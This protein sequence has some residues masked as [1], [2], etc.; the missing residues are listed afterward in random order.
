MNQPSFKRLLP[1]YNTNETD[2]YAMH[3]T[4]RQ[5]DK[6]QRDRRGTSKSRK[7]QASRQSK[8]HRSK[9]LYRDSVSSVEDCSVTANKYDPLAVTKPVN[10]QVVVDAETTLDIQKLCAEIEACEKVFTNEIKKD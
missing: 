5:R 8:R 4:K 3:T 2:D 10:Q 6:S 7:R 1:N 9:S